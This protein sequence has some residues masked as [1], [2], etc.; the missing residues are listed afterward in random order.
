METI[1]LLTTAEDAGQRLDSF[2]AGHIDG[3]TRSAAARL[4]AD[5]PRAG[6]L[7]MYAS[8]GDAGGCGAGYSAGCG[9]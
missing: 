1:T 2:L 8:A 7:C 6:N 4:L 3:L 5:G 9:L